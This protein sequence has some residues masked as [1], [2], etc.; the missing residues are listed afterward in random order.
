[1]VCLG[2][3][4]LASEKSKQ[5]PYKTRMYTILGT[6]TF[7]EQADRASAQKMIETFLPEGHSQLDTAY[8]YCKGETENM[9]W[10]TCRRACI[11]YFRP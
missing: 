8:I 1:M 9:F 10:E 2:P 11:K 6:M 3:G 5:E 7:G 4:R